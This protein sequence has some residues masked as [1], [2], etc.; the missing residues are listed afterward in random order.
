MLLKC[1]H[2][3]KSDRIKLKLH[4]SSLQ[5]ILVH[6]FASSYSIFIL[7]SVLYVKRKLKKER[8]LFPRHILNSLESIDCYFCHVLQNLLGVK[9]RKRFFRQFSVCDAKEFV[10]K[11]GSWS[12]WSEHSDAYYL[13]S[14]SLAFRSIL[15]FILSKDFSSMRKIG[16]KIIRRSFILS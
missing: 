5:L 11:C 8:N 14:S 6:T 1:G 16:G 3:K 9:E 4:F 7:L 15:P 10:R 13:Y 12:N 2:G